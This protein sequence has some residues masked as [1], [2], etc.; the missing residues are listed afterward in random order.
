[1]I[2]RADD[3]ILGNEVRG[4]CRCDG[5]GAVRLTVTDYTE[6]RRLS[7]VECLTVPQWCGSVN[8]AEINPCRNQGRGANDNRGVC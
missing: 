1:M 5:D 6:Q 8:D 2:L 3:M 4:S 7:S